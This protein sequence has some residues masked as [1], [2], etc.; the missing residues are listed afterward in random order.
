MTRDE[1]CARYTDD[2]TGYLLNCFERAVDMKRANGQG[3]GGHA[4]AL[5]GKF[6]RETMIEIRKKVGAMYDD[7]QNKEKPK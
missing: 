1:F 5:A 7:A 3:S 2:L 6:M 4:D